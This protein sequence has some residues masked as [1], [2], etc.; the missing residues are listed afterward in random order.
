VES[1][2]SDEESQAC[3]QVS[4]AQEDKEIG[5]GI[6]TFVLDSLAMAP[7][8]DGR[9]SDI[10][11][12]DIFMPDVAVPDMGMSDDMTM[13]AWS[14]IFKP[15]LQQWEHAAGKEHVR[16]QTEAE[17]DVANTR[18]VSRTARKHGTYGMG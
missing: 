8:A 6:R 11:M 18:R 9:M 7:F 1:A 17:N 14:D 12:P 5:C 3:L 16:S 2:G 15:M 4:V 10:F 13:F